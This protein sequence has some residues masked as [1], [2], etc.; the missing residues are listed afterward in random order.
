MTRAFIA[1]TSAEER[2]ALR[3][4]LLNLEVQVVGEAADWAT[5]QAELPTSR[6]DLLLVDWEMLPPVASV[7][8][9]KL[10]KTCPPAMTI[11]L[12]SC[13][14]ARQQA[15]LSAGADVFISRAEMAE[16]V[17]ERFRAVTATVQAGEPLA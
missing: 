5:T 10:R 12:I 14:D 7:A 15:A 3:L 13:H 16:R 4:L 8:L 11:V 6:S 1:D 9:E 2:S 17:A